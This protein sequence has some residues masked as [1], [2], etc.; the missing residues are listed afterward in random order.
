MCHTVRWEQQRESSD[1]LALLCHSSSILEVHTSLNIP[2]LFWQSTFSFPF[3]PRRQLKHSFNTFLL[4]S[5]GFKVLYVCWIMSI[6]I[7]TQYNL[8]ISWGSENAFPLCSVF[9]VLYSISCWF[10]LIYILVWRRKKCS[11]ALNSQFSLFPVFA[12][13]Q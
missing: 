3:F 10:P 13:P 12:K 1:S 9:Q 2:P 5:V 11:N 8:I 6:S 7:L 4:R